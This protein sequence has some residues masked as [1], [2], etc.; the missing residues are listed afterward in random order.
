MRRATKED[1]PH[2]SVDVHRSTGWLIRGSRERDAVVEL[3]ARS[4][5]R[6]GTPGPRAT[7]PTAR[8]GDERPASRGRQGRPIPRGSSNAQVE[9]Y[10]IRGSATPVTFVVQTVEEVGERG[11]VSRGGDRLGGVLRGGAWQRV[12]RAAPRSI[13]YGAVGARSTAGSGSALATQSSG[14]ERAASCASRRVGSSRS[15]G[16]SVRRSGLSVAEVS[17]HHLPML[18]W[19][20]EGL[21]D[22]LETDAR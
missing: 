3:R 21:T 7:T 6:T 15:T 17:T 8:A 9:R 2:L 13:V 5:S 10:G 20:S 19:R 4:P 16:A 1:V 11:D 12:A 18:R 22:L 14:R